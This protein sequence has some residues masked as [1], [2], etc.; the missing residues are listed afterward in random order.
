MLDSFFET[1]GTKFDAIARSSL[2]DSSGAQ[3]YVRL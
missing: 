2:N 1:S 3:N